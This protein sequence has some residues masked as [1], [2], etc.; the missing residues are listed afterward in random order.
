MRLSIDADTSPRL[1]V[2]VRELAYF[3]TPRFRWAKADLQ[4]K[5]MAEAAGLGMKW[6]RFYAAFNDADPANTVKR[7]RAALDAAEKHGLLA[8]VVIA[9]S[10]GIS[11]FYPAGDELYHR[12]DM[13][14]LHKSYWHDKAYRKHYLPLL[15][16]LVGALHDHAGLGM[17]QLMNEPAIYPQ[18]ASQADADA[19]AQ[20]VDEAAAAIYALDTQH[21]ISVGLINAA[22]IAPPGVDLLTF[23]TEFYRARQHIHV[24][25]CHAYQHAD[26]AADAL[27]DQEDRANA[28]VQAA[29]ATGRAFVWTEFGAS[30]TGNRKSATEQ[31]L[32][33][34]FDDNRSAAALQWGFMP[35]EQDVG[36]GDKNFGFSPASFNKQYQQLGHCSGRWQHA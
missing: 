30:Q 6:V 15:K 20:F 31:F 9:D 8:V 26:T 4:D 19:F 21:P 34:Q 28:D 17:W 35:T 36:V 3:G 25:S 14:H 1:G 22:H 10:I 29:V 12:E 11:G 13:G 7:V 33:R 32:A 2:N 24:V 27:W 23:A 5:F 16:K 18:P